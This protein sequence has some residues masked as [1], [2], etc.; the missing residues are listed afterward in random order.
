MILVTQAVPEEE[1]EMIED[2]LVSQAVSDEEPVIIE[3]SGLNLADRLKSI[4]NDGR[5]QSTTANLFRSFDTYAESLPTR[6]FRD[7]NCNRINLRLYQLP[8]Y[9]RRED[10]QQL[11]HQLM[12]TSGGTRNTVKYIASPSGSGKSSCILPAFVESQRS[13]SRFTH[14][15][16]MAFDNN[17]KRKF[18]V[19][20]KSDIIREKAPTQGAAFV[21]QCLKILL[22]NDSDCIWPARLYLNPDPPEIE[23]STESIDAYLLQQLGDSYNCL[24]HLDEHRKIGVGAQGYKEFGA[25]F[26]RGAME[27][28]CGA[29]RVKVVATYV[30]GPPLPARKSSGVCRD[31]M[32]LPAL[33]IVR[34]VQEVEEL[35]MDYDVKKFNPMQKKIYATLMFRLACKITTEIG[36]ISVIHCKGTRSVTEA[37]L[38]DFKRAGTLGIDR[39]LKARCALCAS[40]LQI[41]SYS[42]K[43]EFGPRLLLGINEENLASFEGQVPD[44]VMIRNNFFSSSL[45]TLLKLRCPSC[46]FYEVGKVILHSVLSSTSV[47]DYSTSKPLEAAYA[48]T[49]SVTSNLDKH[50]KLLASVFIIKCEELVS[51]RLFAG[52]WSNQYN[53]S[54]LKLGT[55][56]YVTKGVGI[57]PHPL[58]DIFFRTRDQL[59]LIDVTAGAEGIAQEKAKKL[60]D[61]IQKERANMKTI[62]GLT[63]YGVV[64]APMDNS[65]RSSY[66]INRQ[67]MVVRGDDARG[68][69]G[70]LDQVFWWMVADSL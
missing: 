4:F 12:F 42:G 22:E 44:I 7:D 64:L 8:Y 65:S 59:V 56:Y 60:C 13:S 33:D 37:F 1:K 69:L 31:P 24:I 11:V 9:A 50:I 3:D 66:A 40:N 57:C 52:K 2:T 26:S 63:V 15:L 28:L 67:V 55:I 38:A 27:A 36:L 58:A 32:I 68:Y 29:A 39:S 43:T 10:M 17:N 25:D 46:P 14:Y 49:L 30:D 48:W 70:G 47:H 54:A 6:E 51:G 35:K 5:Y 23:V 19:D 41:F 45:E 62:S 20:S 34:V 21:L 16:Y 53:I 18:V 61:W